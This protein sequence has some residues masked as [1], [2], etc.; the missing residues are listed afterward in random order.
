MTAQA[1]FSHDV[2]PLGEK[3]RVTAQSAPEYDPDDPVEIL[4]RPARPVL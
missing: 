4:R 1:D 2:G 3:A